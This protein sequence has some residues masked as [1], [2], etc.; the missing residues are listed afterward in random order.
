M[1]SLLISV[2]GQGRNINITEFIGNPQLILILLGPLLAKPGNA[3]LRNAAVKM[4]IA[5]SSQMS[6]SPDQVFHAYWH[7]RIMK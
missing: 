7:A 3:K 1:L 2:L 6:H 4:G 5:T